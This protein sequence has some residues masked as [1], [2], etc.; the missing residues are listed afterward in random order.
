[1]RCPSSSVAKRSLFLMRNSE[2]FFIAILLCSNNILELDQ[3]ASKG[4][5]TYQIPF[6]LRSFPSPLEN[7]DSKVRQPA[8]TLTGGRICTLCSLRASQGFL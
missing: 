5:D 6:R 2:S 8:G 1:M 3:L 7:R 4:I